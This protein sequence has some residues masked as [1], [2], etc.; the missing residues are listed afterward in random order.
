MKSYP[1]LY[2]GVDLLVLS[3]CQTAALEPNQRGKEI[4]SLAG[5]SQRLG[6][7]SVIATLWNA[8]EIGASRL[9][10]KLYALHKLHPD[11]SKAELLRQ[12]QLSLLRGQVSRKMKQRCMMS[13]T[14][15]G[16]AVFTV[17]PV[18]PGSGRNGLIAWPSGSK[19]FMLVTNRFGFL[20]LTCTIR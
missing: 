6:A 15:S 2:S 13:F 19:L 10:I 5:L 4:D 1:G 17:M 9:M 3:A 14:G 18:V 7:A 8:D 12:A 20:A 11:W 16:V